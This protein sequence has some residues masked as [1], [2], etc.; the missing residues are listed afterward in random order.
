MWC[1]ILLGL[2]LAAGTVASRADVAVSAWIPLFKGVDHAVGT[3]FPPTTFSNNGNSFVDSTLQVVHCVRVDLADPDVQLYFTPRAS[4]YVA[5]VSE[6]QATSVSNFLKRHNLQ[7]AINAGFYYPSDTSEGAGVEVFGL[8]MSD[9]TIVSVPDN[10]PPREGFPRGASLM[11]TSNK[12]P[13]FLYNNYSIGP[14][15]A[16]VYNAVSGYYPVVTNGVN[17]GDLSAAAYPDSSYH[18]LEP[19]TALGISE[20][21]RYFYLMTIDG[22]QSGYSNGAYDQE[23]AAWL[24][25]FGAWEGITMDGGGSTSL[26]VV[27]C[28]G[29]PAPLNHSSYV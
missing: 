11:F 14:Y 19:R 15:T 8:T 12:E 10:P 24:L 3:N 1:R 22:R 13:S 16:G 18:N 27:D 23:T 6:T 2:A 29:K 9:G 28:I 26:Y 20:D 17:I 4:N 25:Q 7:V 5:E 21:K